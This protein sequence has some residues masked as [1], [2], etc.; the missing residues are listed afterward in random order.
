MEAKKCPICGM[1][2]FGEETEEICVACRR[3]G[4]TDVEG[5]LKQMFGM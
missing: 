5:R 4:S 2:F 1:Y 3:G